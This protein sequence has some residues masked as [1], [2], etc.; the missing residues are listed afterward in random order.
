MKLAAMLRKGIKAGLEKAGFDVLAINSRGNFRR[1]RMRLLSQHQVDVILDVGAADGGYARDMRELG[2]H[3]H[4]RCFEPLQVS[5]EKLSV[6]AETD[7]RITVYNCALSDSEGEQ[8]IHIAGNLDSSSLREMLPAHFEAAPQTRPSGTEK[9]SISRLDGLFDECCSGFSRPFLK[10]DTQGTEMDVLKGAGDRL[11]QIIGLQVE[12][13]LVPL[14]SGQKLWIEV[15][16][17]LSQHGFSICSLEPG[18]SDARTGRLLQIDGV[19][20]RI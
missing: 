19:F 10:I 5:F 4:F 14:Y 2:Y 20:C 17:F 15:I 9:V 3:G 18:F 16:D 7:H 8:L 6:W 12:L 13:S 1:R 11:N